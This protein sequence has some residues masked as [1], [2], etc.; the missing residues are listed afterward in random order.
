MTHPPDRRRQLPLPFRHAPDYGAVDFVAAPSNRTA[1]VWLART[2]EWPERRLALW[3]GAG[4]GKTHL[5]RIWA[6]RH[7]AAVTA[8][9]DLTGLPSPPAH[10]GVAIDDADRIADERALLHVLNACRDAGLPV[11]IA[12]A[13][14]PSRWPVRLPDLASRLRATM[15]V[16][17][18][19]PDDD[20]LR[21]LLLRLLADRQLAVAPAVQDWLL[22]RL[23]RTPAAIRSAVAALDEAALAASKPITR[24]FAADTLRLRLVRDESRDVGDDTLAAVP[25]R[26]ACDEWRS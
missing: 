2:A 21:I 12:A 25:N 15:A 3:G 22:R 5:L 11:L 4:C 10:G 13:T 19:P 26:G 16:E 23:P 1:L 7:G 6:Q 24:P 20:L 14:P 9:P 8:A 18:A 17:I